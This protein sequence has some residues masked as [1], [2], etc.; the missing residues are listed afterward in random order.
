MQNAIWVVI[1]VL[2]TIWKNRSNAEIAFHIAWKTWFS[3]L[4][5]LSDAADSSQIGHILNP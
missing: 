1:A 2:V 5:N 3:Q 4:R